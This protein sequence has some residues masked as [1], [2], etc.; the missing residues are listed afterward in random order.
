MLSLQCPEDVSWQQADVR[1]DGSQKAAGVAHVDGQ[2]GELAPKSG[3]RESWVP[4]KSTLMLKPEV[5]ER[6]ERST[7][8]VIPFKSAAAQGEA[9]EV[10][11]LDESWDAED[12][13]YGTDSDITVPPE[14][15]LD[16]QKSMARRLLKDSMSL[17]Q[18]A[19]MKTMF[20]RVVAGHS[21]DPY[22]LRD[23]DPYLDQGGF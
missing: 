1:A 9:A 23:R 22:V 14:W 8:V 4:S 5:R 17:V 19:V 15:Q 10:A 20:P 13:P 6:I 18:R 12:A 2:S 11:G 7:G 16:G 21:S 3:E